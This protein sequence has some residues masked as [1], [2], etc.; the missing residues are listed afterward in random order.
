MWST[1]VPVHTEKNTP[2][3]RQLPKDT[4]RTTRARG[5]V[6]RR[7]AR[8]SGA[9]NI[10]VKVM[11]HAAEVISTL[12]LGN[13]ANALPN[14]A[15][16]TQHVGRRAQ[17]AAREASQKHAEEHR[18]DH[19]ER[20]TVKQQEPTPSTI[21]V[22]V[23]LGTGLQEMKIRGHFFRQVVL[24]RWTTAGWCGKEGGFNKRKHLTPEGSGRRDRSYDE[25]QM[26]LKLR[27]HRLRKRRT[28]RNHRSTPESL[29]TESNHWD[30][31]RHERDPT[32][33]HTSKSRTMRHTST[34]SE[35]RGVS[36]ALDPGALSAI[37]PWAC[38]QTWASTQVARHII[39]LCVIIGTQPKDEDDYVFF[40]FATTWV[41]DGSNTSFSRRRSDPCAA[42]TPIVAQSPNGGSLCIHH[43]RM[44]ET[45]SIR[46]SL[47]IH[48][49]RMLESLET[50]KL[51][52]DVYI[53]LRDAF[54]F[55]ANRG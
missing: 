4:E 20:G 44:H 19:A 27:T 10:R 43:K 5:T 32:K 13:H 45:L 54:R 17:E 30:G 47:C 35:M 22:T 16:T 38:A 18:K 49:K 37:T 31:W 42:V 6:T 50:G 55:L 15:M 34:H 3:R 1:R 14:S 41:H 51:V 9:A 46:G 12:T 40:F 28:A 36:R 26:E 8:N 23:K 29:T 24:L 7:S 39:Q 2:G 52:Y 21:M 25:A 48:H 33:R 53:H 11:F